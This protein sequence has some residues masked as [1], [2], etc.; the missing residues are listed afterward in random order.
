MYILFK[1]R[2]NDLRTTSNKIRKV[3]KN[4]EIDSDISKCLVSLYIFSIC[5]RREMQ[6]QKKYIVCLQVLILPYTYYIAIVLAISWR[7]ET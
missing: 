6:T 7:V 1:S 4:P 2:Y 3:L 5:C